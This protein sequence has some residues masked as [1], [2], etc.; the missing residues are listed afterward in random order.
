[1]QLLAANTPPCI[2][3]QR[4]GYTYVP[5][6]SPHPTP[7]PPPSPLPG[8][9][10]EW[11]VA[12]FQFQFHSCV[13]QDLLERLPALLGSSPAATHPST[14]PPSELHPQTARPVNG[15]ET[16][17]TS[18]ASATN[19]LEVLSLADGESRVPRHTAET[20]TGSQHS[21]Q[22]SDAVSHRSTQDIVQSEGP[23]EAAFG[24]DM[25]ITIQDEQPASPP[26]RCL[27]ELA[28]NGR[29]LH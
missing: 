11:V 18:A 12:Q 7:P 10:F 4:Y 19:H 9:F 13:W 3:R 2:K 21:Q 22:G 26:Q 1:M 20:P 28:A 8:A 15:T 5:P 23:A 14:G 16:A 6:D 29:L 27:S 25:R 24:Q 17:A